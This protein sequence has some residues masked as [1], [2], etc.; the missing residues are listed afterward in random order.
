MILKVSNV[1]GAMRDAEL[2]LD[3]ASKQWNVKNG[4]SQLPGIVTSDRGTFQ[5]PSWGVIWLMDGST[6]KTSMIIWD[7]PLNE[8]DHAHNAGGA[9]LFEP[10]NSS[11][12]DKIVNWSFLRGSDAATAPEASGLSPIRQAM[13]EVLQKWVPRPVLSSD[14]REFKDLTGFTTKRLLDEYWEPENRQPPWP[15]LSKHPKNTTFTTCN[16]TMSCLAGK[17]A[18]KLGK[19]LG[20]WLQRGPLQL[21]LVNKDVPGCWVTP[22]NGAKPQVGDFYSCADG[23]QVFGHVGTIGEITDGG[24]WIA[25]D[26]GQGGYRSAN[27]HDFIKRVQRGKM[28]PSHFNGWIDIDI[29]FK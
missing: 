7:A 8:Q 28:I 13:V 3:F 4:K 17:L 2:E 10:A 19:K 12:K 27:K 22:K 20:I 25:V 15:D 11:L 16:L 18:L 1:P 26:G 14:D 5:Q 21:D 24:N 29:Y 23:K 6:A 9:R